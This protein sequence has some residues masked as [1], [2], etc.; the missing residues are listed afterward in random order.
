MKIKYEYLCWLVHRS[1]MFS[2]GSHMLSPISVKK[3][4]LHQNEPITINGYKHAMVQVIAA[5][6]A[7]NRI[8]TIMNP[9]LV[10]DTWILKNIIESCGGTVTLC[11]HRLT[12][13]P[14]NIHRGPINSEE[15]KQI[16]GALYLMP[17]FAVRF[18]TFSFL[19]T[20][21]CQIGDKSTQGQRPSEHILDVLAHFG[22]MPSSDQHI[23][24]PS[25]VTIDIL[26]YS[27]NPKKISGSQ[28]SSATKTAIL[29]ALSTQKTIIKNPYIKAD[30]R[31]L[32]KL[33]TLF[34][35]T[36]SISNNIITVVAPSSKLSKVP[37][38]FFLP[39]CGSEVM[40]YIALSVLA[41]TPLMLKVDNWDDLQK[42][43]EDEFLLLKQMDVSIHFKNGIISITPP[44]KIQSVDI[45][46][47]HH[48][49]QSDHHPFFALMLLRGNRPAMIREFVWK[50]RF[51][52]VEELKKIGVH[53]RRENHV[54]TLTPSKLQSNTTVLS[55][56]DTRAAAVLLVAGLCAEGETIIH[57]IHHLHRGYQDLIPNLK[58]LGGKI[59]T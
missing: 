30:V 41:S 58:K 8:V 32:L 39:P 31:N 34:G 42:N 40:T 11:N 22:F 23:P 46:V 55:A 25:E 5:S 37:I 57:D 18:G 47:T 7:A 45:D 17:A 20:G 3:S 28:I 54:L 9:P 12:I 4:L 14:T 53:A 16:H 24:L 10:D 56:T 50:D 26:H 6:I 19:E 35:F 27:D 2:L 13:D 43:L 51:A 44:Q 52:Y 29:C 33:L 36:I 21:G 15:S 49:I 59:T 48:G 38:E 1:W